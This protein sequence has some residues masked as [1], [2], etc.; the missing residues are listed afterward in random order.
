MRQIGLTAA[1]L[2]MALPGVGCSQ[3]LPF[4]QGPFGLSVE[5]LQVPEGGGAAIQVALL[6]KPAAT[7]TVDLDFGGD[8]DLSLVGDLSS[9]TFTPGNYNVP[10]FIQVMAADDRDSHNGHAFLG[11][12]LLTAKGFNPNRITVRVNE[13]ENDTDQRVS[14]LYRG[15]PISADSTLVGLAAFIGAGDPDCATPDEPLTY[16][17]GD[18]IARIQGIELETG[19]RILAP[20][21][22]GPGT[23]AAAQVTITTQV[24]DTSE[25]YVQA[26]FLDANAV[27]VDVVCSD[28]LLPGEAWDL[29][30]TPGTDVG[31]SA[32]TA[33]LY[34]MPYTTGQPDDPATLCD[35]ASQTLVGNAAAF[36]TFDGTFG[37]SADKGSPLLGP[38]IS[39]VIRRVPADQDTSS[40]GLV[41]ATYNG[42]SNGM[43]DSAADYAAPYVTTQ[44]G[45]DTVL[46]LFNDSPATATVSVMLTDSATGTT[47][48]AGVLVG[49][50]SSALV[51]ARSVAGADFLGGAR[52]QSDQPIAVVVDVVGATPVAAAYLGVRAD[53]GATVMVSPFVVEP[54]WTPYL[55][56]SNL[57]TETVGISLDLQDENGA[58]FRRS[59]GSILAGQ[60]RILEG[61]IGTHSDTKPGLA[62]LS[63]L[64]GQV[65]GVFVSQRQESGAVTGLMIA[66]LTDRDSV[67]DPP[68]KGMFR[69]SAR[70]IGLPLAGRAAH[71]AGLATEVIVHNA[72]PQVGETAF[73]L[74]IYDGALV[75]EYCAGLL[76]RRH[77]QLIPIDFAELGDGFQGP[78]I[79]VATASNQP[80]GPALTAAVIQR[81]RAVGAVAP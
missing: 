68:A 40:A 30:A 32:L 49:S 67:L 28:P 27:P 64:S 81:A 52:I 13:V 44:L 15:V 66:N 58:T 5:E 43:H 25:G 29:A 59:S 7:V 10:Q 45:L 36:A 37:K 41:T 80:G 31:A 23:G 72:N 22:S 60:T 18:N 79:V 62:V 75:R 48:A 76:T 71:G 54:G 39:A 19:R 57:S 50:R 47:F 8:P 21:L 9:L 53:S 14:G 35:Q 70:L 56:G 42:L 6:E 2:M 65:V 24:I 26:V 77:S 38:H 34:S 61:S 73:A 46:H 17:A 63:S 1:V 4:V 74:Y 69:K 3:P 11:I 33:I 51:D 55:A 12:E 20:V 16:T 78:I